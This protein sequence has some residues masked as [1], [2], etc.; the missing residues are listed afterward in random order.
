MS[1]FQVHFIWFLVFL[2][3][4]LMSLV[5]TLYSS[6]NMVSWLV[7]FDLFS[8]WSM[9]MNISFYLDWMAMTFMTT[10]ML[11]STI[12][13]VYSYNYMYPYSKSYYF[14]WITILFVVSM[15]LVITMS[16]MVYAMLGW[17]GLGLVSFFLIVYYQ[18]NS[19]IVSGIFTLLMNRIGDS[20]FL[21]T[22]VLLFYTYDDFFSFSSSLPSFSLLIFLLLTF[23]TKSAIF[24]FSPWLPLAMAAPTPISALVHSSTLVTAGLYLMM[25]FSYLFY[26][27]TTIMNSLLLLSIFTSLYAGLNTVFEMD[28]KKLIA[29]STLSHLGFIGMA[30]SAGLL[31]LSFFHLLAHALFKS[32]LFMTMGDIMINLNHSQDIRYLSSGSLMTP[33]SSLLMSVSIMNLLGIPSMTGY[34]SKDLVLECMNYSNLSMF[35]MSIVYVNVLMTYYYSYKLFYYSFQSVKFNPYQ[36]FHSPVLLH[37]ILMSLLGLSTLF[38][39]YVYM[40]MVYLSV[41]F[42]PVV[43][44][45]KFLPLLLNISLF[46]YLCVF[47]CLPTVLRKSVSSYFS[48]MLFLSPICMSLM[49]KFYYNTMF[50][51]VISIEPRFL[52][53]L[54]HNSSFTYFTPLLTQFYKS[55]LNPY[56][57][58]YFSLFI[59]ILLLSVVWL[60]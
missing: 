55:M 27:N 7:S 53:Q 9:D 22:L 6:L 35:I 24:P 31:Y 50:N 11:I 47:L 42:Y 29:L 5:L 45:V 23:I 4:T 40:N 14:L 18:N 28:L 46:I 52:N 56:Y 8:L 21:V 2:L 20:F 32:L 39:T 16:N 57:S 17:D 44:T 33:F 48:S 60:L 38:F 41:L 1:V 34:F 25:R 12:I 49:P 54:M 10:V 59:F 26:S 15:I 13:M 58:L 43:Y 37:S 3:C 51:S 36:L 19:S 30:Y